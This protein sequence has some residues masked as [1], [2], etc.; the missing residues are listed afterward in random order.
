MA[1]EP[2]SFIYCDYKRQREQ[3]TKQVLSSIFRQIIDVQSDIPMLVQDFYTSH[4]SKKTNLSF[5]EIRQILGAVSRDLY[6]LT[7][8][9]DALDEC[10]TLAR[11]DFLSA[12]QTLRGQCDTR[13]LATS[14]FLPAIESHSAFLGK[15]KFEVR[16]SDEDLERYI[17]SRADQLHGRVVSKPDLFENLVSSAVS[18]VGGMYV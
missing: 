7:I 5:D 18:A 9:F 2:V 6:R 13:L 1:N 15:P 11:Q 8:V 12:V 4:E 14:R 16:A 17:R 3:S 10:E